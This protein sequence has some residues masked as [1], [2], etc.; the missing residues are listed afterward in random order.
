VR[1]LGRWSVGLALAVLVSSCSDGNSFSPTVTNVAGSYTALSFT[2][3]STAG[4]VDLLG[5]GATVEVTLAPNGTTT[6][7]LFVPGAGDNG[8][9]LDADLTGTWTLAG[10]TVTFSQTGDTFIRDVPFTASQNRLTGEGTF[11]GQTVRLVL[12]KTSSSRVGA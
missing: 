4:T 2:V 12:T 1:A 8:G 10:N 3:S 7:R 11:E 6:G 5:L 9:D